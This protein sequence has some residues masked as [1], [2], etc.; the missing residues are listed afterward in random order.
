MDNIEDAASQP[1]PC[2]VAREIHQ[3]LIDM[4]RDEMWDA[5]RELGNIQEPQDFAATKVGPD[6]W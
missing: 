3:A 2:N 5:V 6:G 4:W 1:C